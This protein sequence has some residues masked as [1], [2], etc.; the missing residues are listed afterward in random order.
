MAA[1]P[2]HSLTTGR[3]LVTAAALA[4]GLAVPGTVTS[5][6]AARDPSAEPVMYSS[7]TFAYTPNGFALIGDAEVLQGDNR[8]R[9]ARIE[10]ITDGNQDLSR[11]EA[12][13][14]VYFVT[15]DQTLRGDRAVYD[16]GSGEVVMTGEV[17]VT[18]G[19]NVMTGSR[20]VYNVRNG[21][22]RMEGAPTAAGNRVQ[23]V[24]YPGGQGGD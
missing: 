15:P 11:V 17:I 9:A 24:F 19:R 14:D 20:L 10:A 21:T 4:L 22:A 12:T 23:G 7:A 1:M 2:R 6:N 8:L 16:F 5:Q 13:G 3:L 18:Q